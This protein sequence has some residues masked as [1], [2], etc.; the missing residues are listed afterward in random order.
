MAGRS[1][2]TVDFDT[3]Q[4]AVTPGQTAVFYDDN[5]IL[6]GGFITHANV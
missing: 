6:G 5:E 4:A 2:V 3:P 1:A